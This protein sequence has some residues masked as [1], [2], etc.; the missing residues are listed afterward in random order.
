MTAT[1]R[2]TPETAGQPQADRPKG[3]R[4]IVSFAF[5]RLD[6]TWRRL[7][8]DLRA[9]QARAFRDVAE[10][11]PEGLVTRAYSTMGLRGDVDF[12]LWQVA[13]TL[14]ALR[15][16]ASALAATDLGAYL[17]SPH[18]YLAITRRSMYI[19]SHRHEGQDGRRERVTPAG[20]PYLFVYPFVKTHAWYQLPFPE[21]QRMMDEHI[22]VGHEF[23]SIKINT[24]YSFGLD[25]QEFVVAFEASDPGEFVDLVMKLRSAEQRPYTERDTPIFSCV[26][27]SIAD[28][29]SGVTGVRLD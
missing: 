6:P 26:A 8:T 2:L 12:L 13:P 5:F 16:Y 15:D 17:T 3:A 19:D 29:L 22:K 1:E 7:P 28:V 20:A 25:D 23:P 11:P 14:E 18:R 10:A 4:Q 24:T 9:D 27:G 21:R